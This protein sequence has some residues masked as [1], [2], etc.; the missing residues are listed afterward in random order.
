MLKTGAAEGAL[1]SVVEAEEAEVAGKV[2]G[3]DDGTPNEGAGVDVEGPVVPKLKPC[4][5]VGAAKETP[6]VAL[7]AV[8]EVAALVV[9]G[10]VA[11]DVNVEPIVNPE[12][13]VACDVRVDVLGNDVVVPAVA[14]VGP[15]RTLDAG[16]LVGTV[17]V[18]DGTATGAV[19][20]AGAESE[21]AC[22]A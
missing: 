17:K 22:G 18:T 9:D 6:G 21:S 2:A 15:K 16:W 3:V 1:N 20:T 14:G 10:T 4:A 7:V 19:G 8:N 5:A 11:D 12:G 13:A